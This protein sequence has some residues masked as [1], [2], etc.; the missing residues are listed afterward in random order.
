MATWSGRTLGK[1]QIGDLIA[2][3]GMAEVYEGQ[4]LTLNRR[5]AVKIMRDHVDQDPELRSRFE[6]EAQVVANLHHPN[7][8]QIFDYEILDG[9]PC[10]IMELISSPTLANYLKALNKRGERLPFNMVASIMGKIASAVDYAHERNIVHR[11]IKPSNVLLRSASGQVSLDKPLPADVEPVLTDFGLVR[12]LDSSIQTS[13]GTVT[14]TPTYMSPEQARGERVDNRTDI[15]SLGI[16]LYELVEGKV[17]FDA[18]SSFGVLMKHLNDSPPAITNVSSNL[19]AIIDRA[20]AKEPKLRYQ[21]AGDMVKE[22]TSVFNGETVSFDTMQMAEMAQAVN[23]PGQINPFWKYLSIAGLASLALTAILY[24]S[25]RPGSVNTAYDTNQLGQV[26]F[27]D[28][29]S[30]MDRATIT[31]VTLPVPETGTHYDV[32]FL[33]QGG[34]IRQNAGILT[35]DDNG[36]GE[37]EYINPDGEN[38]LGLYDGVEVTIEADND[39]NPDRSSGDIVASSVFPPL[40]LVHVRHVLYSFQGAPNAGPLVNGLYHTA[41]LVNT[42]TLELKA[43]FE[44]GNESTLRLKNEEIINLIVGSGNTE[45]YLDWNE[46]GKVDDPGDG[47]GLLESNGGKSGYIPTTISHAQFAADA[48]DA[49]S[50]IILHK[51]HV[52]ISAQNV[53]GWSEQLLEKALQLQNMDFG[54]DMESVILEMQFLAQESLIGVDA[55][56]NEQ[57]EPIEGEG[58]AATARDHAYYMGMMPLLPG[59]NQMPPPGE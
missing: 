1:V 29:N 7:I 20:L 25:L 50:N 2:R 43:A 40:A 21:S 37:L 13:T 31:T 14:G 45:N 8:V 41:D 53:H 9:S 33:G 30:Q 35:M 16:M 56:R 54:P 11:D 42:S 24:F 46:N 27:S 6:R 58:G 23:T 17:P 26:I 36:Q 3:G 10:L 49:T 48:T 15:Y 5:V 47:F 55:N 38:I 12:L 22:F 19:Q 28:F 4:H 32:W 18:E 34:E 52:V 39:P 57:I 51:D 44:S 59:A